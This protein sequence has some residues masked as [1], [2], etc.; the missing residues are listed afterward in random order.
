MIAKQQ[1]LQQKNNVIVGI[2]GLSHICVQS[3]SKRNITNAERLK[4]NSTVVNYIPI[5]ISNRSIQK[6]VNHE[7][8]GN[9]S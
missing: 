7:T 8:L 1:Y 5:L 6:I 3:M 2:L 4:E 9:G